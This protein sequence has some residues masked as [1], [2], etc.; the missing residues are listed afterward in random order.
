MKKYNLPKKAPL[1]LFIL[2]LLLFT[3]L[4]AASGSSTGETID[5][6][7]EVPDKH[8]NAGDTFNVKLRITNHNI[9]NFKL[10]GMQTTLSFDNALFEVKGVTDLS[11]R[12]TIAH[13]T[14]TDNTV[15]YICVNDFLTG[16]EG[17]AYYGDVFEISLYAKQDI[18]DAS[19]AITPNN[20]SLL[21]GN[22]NAIAITSYTLTV[23]KDGVIPDLVKG[24][25]NGDTKVT[26]TDAVY[27]LY[28]TTIGN[29]KYPVNQLCDFDGNEAVNGDDAIYLLYHVIFGEQYPLN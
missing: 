17:Y 6:A 2:A 1:L 10:A 24:D 23:V 16:T 18:S 15:K 9:Q 5:F 21:L 27:L 11:G 20:F 4:F 7:L 3:T 25:V 13:Y 28:N 8:I 22:N 29:Q 26:T 14:T 19:T 12:N